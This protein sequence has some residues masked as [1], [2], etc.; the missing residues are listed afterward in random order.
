[1][2]S[3]KTMTCLICLASKLKFKGLY[4]VWQHQVGGMQ[5]RWTTQNCHIKRVPAT[6]QLPSHFKHSLRRKKFVATAF[7]NQPFTH[8]A[9][10]VLLNEILAKINWFIVSSFVRYNGFINA[11]M[12]LPPVTYPPINWNFPLYAFRRYLMHIIYEHILLYARFLLPVPLCLGPS[13]YR[14]LAKFYQIS[15]ST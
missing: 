11:K 8:L 3:S 12:P 6:A 5:Y 15:V 13:R 10:N 14:D 7:L 9:L 1:M 4:K 2:Y